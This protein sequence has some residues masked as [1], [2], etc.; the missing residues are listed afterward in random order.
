M[1]SHIPMTNDSL[2]LSFPALNAV[3]NR[4][5]SGAPRSFVVAPSGETVYFLRTAAAT[6]RVLHLW[7]IDL[8]AEGASERLVVDVGSLVSDTTDIPE[9][10]RQR[11][12][13][14]RESAAGITAF[15]LDA[16]GTLVTFALAGALYVADASGA[17]PPRHIG[18]IEG[19]I[20]PRIDPTGQRIAYVV[21]NELR[22]VTI[23]TAD[24]TTVC[25]VPEHWTVGLANYVAAEELERYRG[26]WW[27][28][29]GQTLAYETADNSALETIWI[30]DP[31]DPRVTPTSRQYPKAGTRNPAIALHF[32]HVDGTTA[33][34]AIDTAAYEYLVTVS[35]PTEAGLL[36]TMMAR[37]HRDQVVGLI[38][39]TTGLFTELYRDHNESFLEWIGG[40]PAF[41]PDGRLLV[42]FVDT[43][44][45]TYRVAV[46][47]DGDAHPFTPVGFQVATVVDITDDA[48]LVVGSSDATSTVSA[49]VAFDGTSE[50][51]GSEASITRTVDGRVGGLKVSVLMDIASVETTYVVTAPDRELVVIPSFATT[52]LAATPPVAPEVHLRTY[53]PDALAV[54]ILFPSAPEAWPGTLPIIMSPYGGPHHQRVIGAGRA[55]AE[56]QYLAD[57]GFCVIVADGRGTG[58]RGPAWDRSVVARLGELAVIDQVNALDGA[59]AEFG[60]RLDATRVGV[61]GWSFGGYLAA[62]C[63]LER[64]DRFHA[65]VAGAPV[66]DWAWYDTGYTER[67]LGHPDYEVAAYR[68][69]N[70]VAMAPQLERPLL[71]LHG[72]L[73]DNV[74]F[75]HTQQ[76]S[77]ALLAAGKAHRVIGFSGVTHMPSDPVVAEHMTSLIVDF[78][79]ETLV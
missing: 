28:P 7:A 25:A 49:R 32:W 11:R 14:M 60:D 48:L 64:P 12:E 57:Q 58:G 52:P 19:A 35:W 72:Y 13:R 41:T 76:L 36:V 38:D 15:S 78:F 43:E 47:R 79:R 56:D 24:V 40:L 5:S 21:G 74:L 30:A 66:T 62:R 27:S 17:T 8:D 10:E 44:A 50:V 2:A 4:F 42:A 61:R 22:V 59:L 65:A 46:V 54:A 23:A 63:V 29:D 71:F 20:D 33:Q 18:D 68:E 16:T 70:L 34:A 26:H 55:Y 1:L 3:T 77:D 31:K 73:D 67:Y 53:G 9:A 69:A 6:D 37:S 51:A 45:D 75:A 39:T